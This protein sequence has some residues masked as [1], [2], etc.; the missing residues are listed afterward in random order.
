M[1]K[2]LTFKK[3][4]INHQ[5]IRHYSKMSNTWE[6]YEHDVT[7]EDIPN[8]TNAMGQGV[9][10]NVLGFHPGEQQE[11]LARLLRNAHEAGATVTRHFVEQH[12]NDFAA[13]YNNEVGSLYNCVN[14]LEG[15]VES[16]IKLVEVQRDLLKSY[17]AQLDQLPAEAGAGT[18]VFKTRVPEPPTF[19]GSDN[20][21]NL[22][23]WM[24]QIS[25][26]CSASGTVTDKQ[27]IV[28]ALTRLRQ[29]AQTYMKKYFTLNTE[30]KDMGSWENFQKELRHIYGR[31]DELEGAKEELSALWTNKNLASKDFIKFAEQYRTLARLV[32]YEDS[33][34]ID[35]LKL[36]IPS[37]LRNALVMYELTKNVPSTWEEYLELLLGAYKALHPEKSK[38]SIF[39]KGNTGSTGMKDPDAMEIDVASKNK[40]K[41]KATEANLQEAK[42]NKFCQ[43]CAGKGFKAKSKTHNT[44]DCYDKPGNESKHPPPKVTPTSTSNSIQKQ[45]SG[46]T[47]NHNG[48]AL[49]AR[50]LALLEEMEEDAVTPAGTTTINT[51]RIEEVQDPDPPAEKREPVD[52]DGAQ[53]GPS[54]MTVPARWTRRNHSLDFPKGL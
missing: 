22:E 18:G 14:L 46:K 54:G 23:D 53:A 27:K 10:F 52:S 33:I 34:H 41:G 8:W 11:H 21:M 39:G 15:Q 24:D 13:D 29:P 51:A 44:N 16:L 45:G 12:I 43:I 26:F 31:R 7:M 38:G 30:G 40:G 50:L 17:K 2:I 36:V 19:S 32:G 9:D 28:C 4:S 47:T 37:E 25:L 42:K 49:K 3:L 1:C 6:N 5:L 20:K 48:K 35:K